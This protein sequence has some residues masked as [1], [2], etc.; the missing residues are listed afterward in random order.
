MSNLVL[1]YLNAQNR[2]FNAQ[3]I[4]DALGRHGI[5]KGMAQKHLDSLTEKGE[6]AVEVGGKSQVWYKVQ[7]PDGV[8]PDDVLKEMEADKKIKAARLAELNGEV[9]KRKARM[10]QMAKQLTT[11]QM[12][13]KIEQLTSENAK[14]EEKLVPMRASKGTSVSASEMKKMEDEFD[15]FADV[16]DVPTY[17]FRGDEERAFVEANLNTK[18]FP[19]VNFI[20]ADGKVTKYESEVRTVEA[21]KEFVSSQK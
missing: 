16:A 1:E 8:L 2:P 21:F 3:N 4:A 13:I 9:A 11:K 18:S 10:M 15:K 17:K 6:I 5:K 20:S 14:M 7:D 19:T 12:N